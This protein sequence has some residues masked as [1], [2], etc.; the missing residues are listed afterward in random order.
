MQHISLGN[1]IAELP[2]CEML[3]EVTADAN[4]TY[5]CMS[6]LLKDNGTVSIRYR[7]LA[8]IP[9]AKLTMA[10]FLEKT[11]CGGYCIMMGNSFNIIL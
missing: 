8:H 7:F 5:H 9:A 1:Y 3:Y 10:V 11:N 2:P 4:M 6:A